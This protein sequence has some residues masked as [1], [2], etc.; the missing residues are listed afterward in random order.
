[1][2]LSN[3][4]LN[5]VYYSTESREELYWDYEKKTIDRIARDTNSRPEVLIFGAKDWLIR[6]FSQLSDLVL[7]ADEAGR[8]RWKQR[9]PP[10]IHRHLFPVLH[11]GARALLYL[12]VAYQPD[13]FGM[14]ISQLTFLETSV[15]GVF[16]SITNLQQTIS[17]NL[18]K[19]FFR[20]RNLFECMQMKSKVSVPK[21]PAPYKSHPN[22]MKIEVKDL[23]FGY[24]KDFPPVLKN[25]NFTI[26]PGQIVSIVGYNGSG[27]CP[28]G[29][30]LMH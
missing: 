7:A 18:V 21:N 12:V 6:R 15:E 8:F 20:I 14:P 24:K 1:V 23:T 3:D 5:I 11:S 27:K 25:V 2:T 30:A 29:I 22:G 4:S 19:D 26:E 9:Q 10:F 28:A 13:Y 17:K 16:T